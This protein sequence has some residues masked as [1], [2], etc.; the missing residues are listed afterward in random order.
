MDMLSY[1]LG[2]L[3]EGGTGGGGGV[4]YTSIVY[5]TDNTITLTDTDG[6]VHTMVCTYDGAGK[7]VSAS[8]DNDG[9]SLTYEGDVLVKVGGT[10][11]DVGNAPN[12][13]VTTIKADSRASNLVLSD[14]SSEVVIISRKITTNSSVALAEV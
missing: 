9:I 2:R 4:T 6:V 7:L 5:N 1:F 13:P 12:E 10:A 3:A 11:V 14:V 8:Y